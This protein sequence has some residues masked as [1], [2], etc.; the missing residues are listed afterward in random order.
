LGVMDEH[1][2]ARGTMLRSG[3]AQIECAIRR[4]AEG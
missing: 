4:V 3:F 2:I 1:L